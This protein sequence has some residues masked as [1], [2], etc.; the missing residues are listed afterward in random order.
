[1]WLFETLPSCMELQQSQEISSKKDLESDV[2]LYLLLKTPP[3][4]R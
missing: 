1:M 3:L 2:K 4:F